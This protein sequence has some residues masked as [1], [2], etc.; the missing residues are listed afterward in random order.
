MVAYLA[1]DFSRKDKFT[2]YPEENTEG[3]RNAVK[4][5]SIDTYCHIFLFSV[6]FWKHFLT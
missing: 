4:K 5:N 3:K 6:I 1:M 2:S